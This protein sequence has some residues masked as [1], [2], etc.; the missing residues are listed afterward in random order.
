MFF[1]HILY[2]KRAGI[3]IK[4]KI[5]TFI[6]EF[7]KIMLP[8]NNLNFRTKKRNFLKLQN[9]QKFKIVEV[10]LH[11][12]QKFLV[13]KLKSQFCYFLNKMNFFEKISDFL[14]VNSNFWE[15][16]KFMFYRVI[17]IFAPKIVN[18]NHWKII[19]FLLLAWKFKS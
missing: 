16:Q 10:L 2:L 6:W 1:K 9:Q 4:F 5:G 3:K 11:Y 7:L 14:I 17:W 13:Q 12:N 18:K 15:S 8:Q 19:K